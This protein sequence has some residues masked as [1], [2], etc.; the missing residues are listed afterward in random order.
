M[1]ILVRVWNFIKA[2]AYIRLD[3]TSNSLKLKI[4]LA[5]LQWGIVI[6]VTIGMFNQWLMGLL[7]IDLGEH[8]IETFLAK[9]S[10]ISLF[11]VAVILAPIVEETLF[12]GP[13][14]WFR[15]TKYFKF[16][17]Y[18]SVLL[19]AA[20]HLTNFEMSRQVYY[21]APLLVAPQLILGVFLGYVRVKMGLQ[22]S[23]CLHAMYNGVLITPMLLYK[24]LNLPLE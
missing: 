2:P 19:F 11:F 8:A 3:H 23:I 9:Y 20:V 14:I 13:L 12:R 6:G 10:V 21:I 18:A 16:G 22:W 7:K 24:F 4:V 15:N 5:L 17:I 1:K